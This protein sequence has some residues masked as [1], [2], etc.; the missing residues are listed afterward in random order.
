MQSKVI[1]S[2][3]F[4]SFYKRRAWFRLSFCLRLLSILLDW[5]QRRRSLFF[6][7]FF[8]CLSDSAFS[9]FFHRLFSSFASI[10]HL[11]TILCQYHQRWDQH[12][13]NQKRKTRKQKKSKIENAKT[14]KS[15]TKEESE[16]TTKSF[17]KVESA[18]NFSRFEEI[19]S[20]SERVERESTYK[21][22]LSLSIF[23]LSF[24]SR[25]IISA[26]LR[27]KAKDFVSRVSREFVMIIDKK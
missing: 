19:F 13:W 1:N 26:D 27:K 21:D 15:N 4:Y 17:S 7:W 11:S 10:S 8:L 14:E 22:F 16:T 18:T 3:V 12:R 6:W 20:D 2:I 23:C 5:N 25:L 24:R 9:Y